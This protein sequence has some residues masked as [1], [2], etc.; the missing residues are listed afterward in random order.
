M[1]TLSEIQDY[2]FFDEGSAPYVKLLFR[3]AKE[4]QNMYTL[5]R[6]RAAEKSSIVMIQAS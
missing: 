1:N 3:F 2:S 6:I 4:I 5:G